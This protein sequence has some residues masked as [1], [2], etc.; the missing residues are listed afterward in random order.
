[1]NEKGNCACNNGKNYSDQNIFASMACMS[2]NDECPSGNF[3]DNLQ[4]TNWILYYGAT[5]HMIPEVSDFIQGSLKNTDKHIEV[6][7]RHHV[8]KK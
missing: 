8:T 2:G 6:V 1:M 5:C 7:D 4:L 3:G